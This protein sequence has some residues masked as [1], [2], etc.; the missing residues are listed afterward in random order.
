MSPCCK[1]PALFQGRNLLTNG[2]GSC[3]NVRC[4][5]FD[6]LFQVVNDEHQISAPERVSCTSNLFPALEQ[7]VV[8]R[9]QIIEWHPRPLN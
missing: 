7:M 5:A 2:T 9:F 4:E 3:D 8:K 1:M 6:P